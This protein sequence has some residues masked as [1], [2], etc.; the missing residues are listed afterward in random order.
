MCYS[1]SVIKKTVIYIYLSLDRLK[2]QSNLCLL[3]A[4]ENTWH[5]RKARIRQMM[6]RE[7]PITAA[8]MMYT[9]SFCMPTS[10][11]TA[12]PALS[13]FIAANEAEN[14]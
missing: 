12:K 10:S 3:D 5:T 6:M 14:I 11:E 2:I 8:M 7:A 13:L 4:L 9:C 1:K